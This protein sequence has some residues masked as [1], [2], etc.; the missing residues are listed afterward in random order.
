[1]HYTGIYIYIYI[2]NDIYTTASFTISVNFNCTIKIG[3]LFID[4]GMI[5][6]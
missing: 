1:M 2:S 4:L 3:M 6:V 5:V